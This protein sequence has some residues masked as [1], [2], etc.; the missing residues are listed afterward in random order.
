MTCCKTK[1]YKWCKDL[2]S[3]KA[4]GEDNEY[5][6]FHA[7]EREKGQTPESFNKDREPKLETLSQIRSCRP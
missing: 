6:V 2:R 7:S 5:C 4:V 3:I 1:E